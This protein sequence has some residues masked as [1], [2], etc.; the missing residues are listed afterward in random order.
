MR[1]MLRVLLRMLIVEYN[2]RAVLAARLYNV[3]VI[4]A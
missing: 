1:D 3:F 4:L 2:G